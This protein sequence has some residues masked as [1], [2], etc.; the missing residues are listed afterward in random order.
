MKVYFITRFSIFDPQ[1]GGF[2]ITKDY[3]EKAYEKRLFDQERLN[4][5]FDTLENI[6]MRSIIKQ[7]C[8]NWKW[9]IYTAERLP[10]EYMKRLLIL[11]KEYPN[12]EVI[13]VKDFREFFEKDLSYNY[14]DSFATVRLD[15]DDG[16]NTC[17]V[18]KLQQYSKNVG[19][20][21]CF[22][23][24]TLVKYVKGRMVIGEKVSEKNNAQGLAGIGVK[25]YSTGRHSDIDTR[26][27]V[28]EDH[29]PD[30]FLM[31]CSP[32]TDTKRGFTE[33]ERNFGKL[34]RLIFLIFKH[35]S[36]VPSTISEFI[37]KR[38]KH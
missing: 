32:F 20:I 1:F 17:F 22:T 38:L 35:P 27:N 8:D 37:R 18:E 24:G 34:K 29:T 23:E 26:Y 11:M 9:L 2:R 14:E 6:T 7:S 33:F 10:E 30:M 25:I 5:R 12:I 28:I 13:T 4:H 3:D 21:V 31:T 15:D 16:L 19:S 36:Q